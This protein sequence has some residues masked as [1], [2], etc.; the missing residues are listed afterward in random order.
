MTVTIRPCKKIAEDTFALLEELNYTPKKKRIFIKPNI[1][2]AFP[3]NS[4]YISNPEVVRGIIRYLKAKDITDITVGEGS[5]GRD[6]E[7]ISKKSGYAKMCQ[8]EGVSLINLDKAERV[9]VPWKNEKLK[10][11]KIAIESEY[12]DV[13]KLKTHIQAGITLGLK[14][15][16]GLLALADKR[17]FHGSLHENIAHLAK[18]IQPDL[19]IIDATNGVEGNGPG[20]T[21][22]AVKGINLLIGG[23]DFLLTDATAARLM[24][25]KPEEV[26][27]LAIAKKLGVGTFEGEVSGLN[28]EEIKMDFEH[29]GDHINV[30]NVYYWWTEDTCSGCSGMMGEVKKRAFRNPW[31]LFKLAYYGLLKRLDILTGR[32]CPVQDPHGK[33]LCVGNCTKKIAEKGGYEFVP[34]CPPKPEDVLK[35]L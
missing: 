35:K 27:H 33:V 16:K 14:N 22:K 13:A 31:Y 6:F 20:P 17:K 12:I 24:G 23:T 11:P 28:L 25:Y 8:E 2:D 18:A 32:D 4:P 7:A 15:Q 21:G 5:V 10:L 9:E 26:K 30:L 3:A 29:P 19:V 1:V 34:G